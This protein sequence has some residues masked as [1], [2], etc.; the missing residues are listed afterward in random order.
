MELEIITS[1]DC[2]ASHW[3][4]SRPDTSTST[5]NRP[6]RWLQGEYRNRKSELYPG[7]MGR[8]SIV[9][10]RLRTDWV[11]VQFSLIRS[12]LELIILLPG[13]A[14]MHQGYGVTQQPGPGRAGEVGEC[15]GA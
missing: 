14:A 7:L 8:S 11:F 15:P 2:V 1:G 9:K 4:M 12:R 6:I 5:T 3:S 10:I 13:V